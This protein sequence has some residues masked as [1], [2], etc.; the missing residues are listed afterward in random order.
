MLVGIVEDNCFARGLQGG[1]RS[2]SVTA[3]GVRQWSAILTEGGYFYLDADPGFK[4]REMTLREGQVQAGH[5]QN[6][7]CKRWVS[8]NL[9]ALCIASAA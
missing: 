5:D 9:D 1:R 6:G 4:I 3:A 7:S 2:N 8:S